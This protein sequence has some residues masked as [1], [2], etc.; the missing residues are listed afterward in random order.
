MHTD[1][2]ALYRRIWES[3]KSGPSSAIWFTILHRNLSALTAAC[4]RKTQMGRTLCR[5]IGPELSACY[6]PPRNAP[7]ITGL[8]TGGNAHDPRFYPPAEEPILDVGP[9]LVATF[10]DP[11]GNWMQWSQRKADG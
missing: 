4:R 5:P 11:A 9:P 1:W 8:I 2:S 6:N 10:I 3:P 7:S